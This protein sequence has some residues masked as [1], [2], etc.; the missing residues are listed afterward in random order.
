MNIGEA[1]KRIRKEKGLTQKALSDKSKVSQNSLSLIENGHSEPS[2][3]I[4]IKVCKGLG[5]HPYYLMLESVERTDIPKGK[6]GVFDL[7]I[8]P[9]KEMGKEL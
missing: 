7:L 1:I 6:L 8:Q 9:L 4:I 3:A 2:Q 5:I